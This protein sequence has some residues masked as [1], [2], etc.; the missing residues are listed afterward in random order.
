MAKPIGHKIEAKQKKQRIGYTDKVTKTFYHLV[1]RFC[2]FELREK[3]TCP[4]FADETETQTPFC[5]MNNT[6]RLLQKSFSMI[7]RQHKLY[8]IN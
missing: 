1:E 2:F 6:G 7:H 8:F 3:K 4:I 5:R